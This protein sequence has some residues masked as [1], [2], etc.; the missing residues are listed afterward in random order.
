[1]QVLLVQQEQRVQQLL[2]Q[3]DWL[4]RWLLF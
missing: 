2:V 3:L 4:Q 1:M